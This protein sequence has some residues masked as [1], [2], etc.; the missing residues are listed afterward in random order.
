LGRRRVPPRVGGQILQDRLED[1]PTKIGWF[2]SRLSHFKCI[3]NCEM[4]FVEHCLKRARVGNIPMISGEISSVFD[5]F[6]IS[7]VWPKY[8]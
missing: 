7:C 8:Y 5:D 4:L 3:A 2:L 1:L 6:P